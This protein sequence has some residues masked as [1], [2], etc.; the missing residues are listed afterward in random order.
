MSLF[1]E[2]AV[3]CEDESTQRRDEFIAEVDA[4][5]EAMSRVREEELDTTERVRRVMTSQRLDAIRLKAKRDSN[6]RRI[7]ERR[8]EHEAQKLDAAVSIEQ[9]RID[10][11]AEVKRLHNERVMADEATLHAE[12]ERQRLALLQRSRA[13]VLQSR[14]HGLVEEKADIESG[15]HKK[16]DTMQAKDFT[17]IDRIRISKERHNRLAS[18]MSNTGSVLDVYPGVNLQEKAATGSAQR[19]LE[20][21]S[22]ERSQRNRIREDILDAMRM[23]DAIEEQEVQEQEKQREAQR[24]RLVEETV[25]RVM[26]NK[27]LAKQAQE[28]LYLKK[29]RGN[30]HPIDILHREIAADLAQERYREKRDV[31][32]HEHTFSANLDKYLQIEQAAAKDMFRNQQHATMVMDNI[33]AEEEAILVEAGMVE[34]EGGGGEGEGEGGEGVEGE[35]FEAAAIGVDPSEAT[36]VDE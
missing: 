14:Y 11:N 24:V 2:A 1:L 6:I 26:E 5:A 20:Q 9:K 3:K 22:I 23:E 16:L 29:V 35:G 15:L 4:E 32:E 34:G 31:L 30:L 8:K 19:L 12:R 27:R 10:A 28:A 25:D 7:E 36:L 13:E 33:A 17:Y 21:V 18:L